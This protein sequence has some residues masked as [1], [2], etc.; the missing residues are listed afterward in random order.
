MITKRITYGGSFN[1]V[2]KAHLELAEIAS[3]ERDAGDVVFA[4]TEEHAFGVKQLAPFVDRK[5][6]LINS[7]YHIPYC[8]VENMGKY[9]WDY[10]RTLSQDHEYVMLIGSDILQDLHKWH[11]YQQ[12]IDKYEFWIAVRGKL[13]EKDLTK[14]NKYRIISSTANRT[15]STA[16]RNKLHA[17]ES[18]RGLVPE[19]VRYS[20]ENYFKGD[21]A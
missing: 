16:V 19:T 18:I 4:I 5:T 3:H 2:T 9:M 17:G 12:L 11:N 21:T 13:T 6:W 8:W 14:V 15:S 7:T 1:P 10:L 20:I